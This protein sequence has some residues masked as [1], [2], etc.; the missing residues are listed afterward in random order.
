MLLFVMKLNL[1]LLKYENKILMG[2]KLQ[3]KENL[4]KCA[5]ATNWNKIILKY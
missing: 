5:L 4:K 1:K 3:L 2:E